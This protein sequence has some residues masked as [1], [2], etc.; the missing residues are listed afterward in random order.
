[1]TFAT[2]PV[3]RQARKPHVCDW[4][5][6]VIE[7]RENYLIWCWFDNGS[8]T[9]VKAHDVCYEAA[10]NVASD[11]GDDYVEFNRSYGKGKEE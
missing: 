10:G 11:W 1:M 6:E 5:G 8:A 7:K 9:T 2:P 4:C 3:T